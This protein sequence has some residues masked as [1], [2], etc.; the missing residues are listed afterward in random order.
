M[1]VREP[2]ADRGVAV[3]QSNMRGRLLFTKLH[4]DLQCPDT[5]GMLA[6]GSDAFEPLNGLE[7]TRQDAED[8]NTQLEFRARSELRH[9]PWHVS[10]FINVLHGRAL[11]LD[12]E[13]SVPIDK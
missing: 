5:L 3:V 11:M 8:C 4:D 12:K 1:G 9:L 10:A 7:A 13:A 2:C 6:L